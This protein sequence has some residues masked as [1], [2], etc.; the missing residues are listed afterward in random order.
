MLGRR[1]GRVA[2][3]CFCQL[4]GLLCFF[5]AAQ[6]GR[7][8]NRHCRP[9]GVDI[10]LTQPPPELAARTVVTALSR[11]NLRPQPI[12]LRLRY[13]SPRSRSRRSRQCHCINFGLPVLCPATKIVCIGRGIKQGVTKETGKRR[14]EGQGSDKRVLSRK[15]SKD[16]SEGSEKQV[17]GSE[18]SEKQVPGSEASEKQ[19]AGS[20]KNP[21]GSEKQVWGS[22]KWRGSE[23]Q[24]WGSKKVA[25]FEMACDV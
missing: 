2:L 23:K 16:Q 11:S 10:C 24:D 15:G 19:V 4:D 1:P 6:D 20:A 22:E 13:A 14:G 7:C 21:P 12:I 25:R 17:P 18:G 9:R 8:G 5:P 3:A